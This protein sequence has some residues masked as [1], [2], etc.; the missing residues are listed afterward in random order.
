MLNSKAHS[1]WYM[2]VFVFYCYMIIYCKLCGLNQ[3]I[4]TRRNLFK[5]KEKKNHLFSVDKT[6]IQ[7]WHNWH[8][9]SEFYWA[10][11]K[12]ISQDCSSNLGTGSSSSSVVVGRIQFLVRTE[13][14][15]F[16]PLLKGYCSWLLE[17]PW[18][19]LPHDP[20]GHKHGRLL[21][22]KP[23]RMWGFLTY[24]SVTWGKKITFYF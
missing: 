21:S 5:K 2:T 6:F 1:Y 24:S 10:K 7:E 16:L 3:H 15:V 17:A 23:A 8:V 4:C 14:P 13:V 9:C 19:S 12:V 18:S 11:V 20:H 22:S